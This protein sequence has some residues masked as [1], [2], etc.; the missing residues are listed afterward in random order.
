VALRLLVRRISER[1]GE[2]YP[3]SCAEAENPI[4]AHRLI[5]R[6]STL[7]TAATE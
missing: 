1:R 6:Q 2:A 7:G 4:L 5:A 3:P